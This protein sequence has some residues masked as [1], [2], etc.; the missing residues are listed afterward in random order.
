EAFK[1]Y[2]EH[3][4]PD[5]MIAITRWEFKQPREALRV[6]AVAM[7][8]LHELG[9]P[10]PARNFIV[11]SEGALNADGRPVVVV[12]KKTPVTAEEEAAVR[13]HVAETRLVAQYLPSQP[14]DNAFGQL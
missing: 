8:A 10:N 9:V 2:F 6:L 5:G 1:E 11:A 13:G 3:L 14:Q 7:Q 4:K 12:A